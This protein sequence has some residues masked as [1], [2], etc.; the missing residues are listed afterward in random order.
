MPS[1]T[2]RVIIE[3]KQRGTGHRDAKR[4]MDGLA[5]AAKFAAGAFAVMKSAQAAIDFVK[6]GA[7]VERQRKALDNLAKTADTSGDAIV[8]AIQESSDYT[9]DRMTAMSAASK[10]MIMDVADSPD[11]FERLTRV[12]TSLG[13]AMGQDAAKSIDDFVVAAARQSK[14]IADNLGLVVSVEDAT[15]KY[16][17]QLGK[18]AESMTDAE[19]KQAFLNA[20]L[21]AG[22]EKM[23]AL[24]DTSDDA[25]TNIEKLSAGFKDAK[26]DLAEMAAGAINAIIPFDDLAARFR[27]L[28]DT[29]KE[30]GML[31]Q[32]VD[33]FVKALFNSKDPLEE[34]E[35]GVSMAYLASEDFLNEIRD[36]AEA[37]VDSWARSM[38]D[39]DTSGLALQLRMDA[40]SEAERRWTEQATAQDYADE[41]ANIGWQAESAMVDLAESID[42][43]NTSSASA[44]EPM[45]EWEGALIRTTEQAQAAALAQMDLAQQLANA[46]DAQIAQVAIDQLKQALDDGEIS[47]DDYQTAVTETQLAF[48]LATPE[49]I[50][51]SAA[52]V[53]LSDALASGEVGASAYNE[54]LSAV[55]ANTQAGLDSTNALL[56]ALN[57][58]SNYT[59]P[60]REHGGYQPAL[61][62]GTN[63]WP[64]GMALVGEAGPELAMLPRGARVFSNA[65]SRS[66]T[67]NFGGNTTNIYDQRAAHILAEQQRRNQRAALA[68]AM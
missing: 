45:D 1:D 55:I 47:F 16:A 58:V 33:D 4:G 68:R 60:T 31:A 64:G 53:G 20:M 61:Q 35:R 24:G 34:F 46:T 17:V 19:K 13:R 9:I 27:K 48:G 3:T 8:R 39:A 40:I 38:D 5:K 50:N 59:S 2:V 42:D 49:S 36:E 32:G 23:L 54:A 6:F 62:H 22:E 57:Q 43:V 25:A 56:D 7:G 44:I 41:L 18:S 28:P 37:A 10:A 51:L 29:I 26:A 30:L 65:Q 14:Q 15:K 52:L 66:L 67:N 21:E 63:Y 12:A 11:E